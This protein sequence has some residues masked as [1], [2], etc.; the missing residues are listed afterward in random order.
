LNA[1]RLYAICASNSLENPHIEAVD[2]VEFR[3]LAAIVSGAEYSRGPM[4]PADVELYLSVVASAHSRGSVLPAPPGTVFRSR[5]NLLRWMELHY[6]T[7]LDA[8]SEVEGRST[9]RLT[10][11]AKQAIGNE[12]AGK[13]L[14]TH[15]ANVFRTLRSSAEATVSRPLDP[16]EKRIVAKASFL[17]D[18]ENWNS[19]AEA[20]EAERKR[21]PE[22]D[23]RMTGPWPPYDFVQMQFGG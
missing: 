3:E 10:V 7:L 1:V 23:F 19:F 17:V 22:L 11:S 13:K 8:L 14:Q 9:A 6:F 4:K 5:D 21:H 12:D 2:A 15:A 18:L 20:L 16:D